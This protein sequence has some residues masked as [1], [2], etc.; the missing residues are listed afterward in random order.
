MEEINTWH[1]HWLSFSQW[2]YT[3][4][5]IGH[6]NITRSVSISCSPPPHVF[7][8]AVLFTGG[9]ANVHIMSSTDIPAQEKRSR[10]PCKY[11]GLWFPKHACLRQKHHNPVGTTPPHPVGTISSHA[12]RNCRNTDRDYP[13]D[14]PDRGVSAHPVGVFLDN[15]VGSTISSY[16]SYYRPGL[17][18][19]E[20][21]SPDRD[22]PR[23]RK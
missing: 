20:K 14:N 10:Q 4:F 19:F 8:W 21:T 23:S 5:R 22:Y 17:F 6:Y 9:Y 13:V 1:I 2:Y 3:H 18:S 11:G 15:P 7:F 16:I 12:S